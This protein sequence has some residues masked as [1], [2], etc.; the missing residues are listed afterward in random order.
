[1]TLPLILLWIVI[2]SLTTIGASYYVRKYNRP[3]A[4][5]GLYI[6]LVTV[7][8]I[9]AQKVI[10]YDFGSISFFAT[11]GTILFAVTYLVTDIVNEKFGRAEASR[12]VVL[13]FVMQAVVALFFYMVIN[14]VPAPFY[15]NQ[16]AL[17][18]VLGSS[19]RIIGASLLAFIVCEL[20]DVYLFHWLKKLTDGKHLWV[21][22]VFSSLP[23]MVVDSIFFVTLAFY[24]VQPIVPIIIG[25]IVVKWLVGIM[26]IPFMYLSRYIMYGKNYPI[27]PVA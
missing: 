12:M 20:M 22:S 5:I 2:I 9:V 10:E 6:T 13:A 26:D 7:A 25:L 1:M 21:R 18:S 24:G 14:A 27:K 3:D 16:E 11:S 19:F 23:T 8:N 17:G 15:T 4:L